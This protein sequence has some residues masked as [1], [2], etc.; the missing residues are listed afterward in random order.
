MPIW[1]NLKIEKDRI[2]QDRTGCKKD[3][4][5]SCPS[6]SDSE[7][8]EIG[9]DG[10]PFV[11][12]NVENSKNEYHNPVDVIECKSEKSGKNDDNLKNSLTKKD[13]S[14]PNLGF[15]DIGRHR[16]GYEDKIENMVPLQKILS[17]DTIE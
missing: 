5:L 17:N 4:F 2:G 1:D 11:V 16:T 9:Q 12:V 8:T 14:C 10:N 7:K 15:Y 6:S 3:G 13:L